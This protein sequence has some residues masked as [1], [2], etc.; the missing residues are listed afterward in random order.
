M[1]TVAPLTGPESH[2]RVKAMFDDIRVMRK[3]DFINN[4]WRHLAL[5]RG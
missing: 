5:D 3:T 1:P 4:L 2:P